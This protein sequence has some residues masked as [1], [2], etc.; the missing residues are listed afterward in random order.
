MSYGLG[1]R[2]GLDLALLC[3]WHRPAATPPIGP[4]AWERPYAAGVAI[5]KKKKKKKKSPPFYVAPPFNINCPIY[6][7]VLPLTLPCLTCS[8]GSPPPVLPLRGLSP[9]Q[10]M[11]QRSQSA[12]PQDSSPIPSGEYCRL[13]HTTAF[14]ADPLEIG[15]IALFTHSL[16]QAFPPW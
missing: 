13:A 6:I 11:G 2:P 8:S 12:A 9:F 3:L 5:K 10:R 14:H 15:F 7:I 4:L 1:R 16:R